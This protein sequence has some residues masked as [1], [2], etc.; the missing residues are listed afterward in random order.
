MIRL[1]SIALVLFLMSGFSNSRAQNFSDRP[2]NLRCWEG[3]KLRL[4][5][6]EVTVRQQSKFTK[7][8][9][10][11]ARPDGFEVTVQGGFC[12]LEELRVDVNPNIVITPPSKRK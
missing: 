12:L 11:V 2:Y 1:I 8:F 3:G 6:K 4:D 9:L 7:R 10:T 5:L